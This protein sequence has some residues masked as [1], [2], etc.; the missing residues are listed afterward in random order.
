MKRILICFGYKGSGYSGY[1]KQPTKVTVQECIES[2]LQK[3]TGEKITIYSSGRTDA[4]VHAIKQYAHFDTNSNIAIDK[5]PTA[6]NTYLPQDIRV[7]KAKQ[8]DDNFHARYDVKKKTYIYVF[9]TNGVTSPLFYDMV[10]P[11]KYDLNMQ[12]V[13]KAIKLIKG[14]HNFKAFC[15]AGASTKDFEREIFDIQV[16]NQ[17]NYLIFKVIGNGFLYNMVRIIVGTIVDVGRGKIEAENITKMFETGQRNLGGK[18]LSPCG[19]YLFDV[20]Y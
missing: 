18:T 13:Q 12:K 1:Q 15:S 4:G 14:K 10:T 5:I 19:L 9:D 8:V 7:F 11:L 16:I 3:F 2:A 6:I 17:G 20:E